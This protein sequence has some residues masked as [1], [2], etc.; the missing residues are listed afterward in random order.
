MQSWNS[1]VI[2][3]AHKA[4]G[5]PVE[6]ANPAFCKMTVYTINELRG[7]S[8]KMLQGPDTDPEVINRSRE[9]PE[10]SVSK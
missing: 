3:S 5:Y 6:I 9:C 7:H 2:T 10:E 8:L 1:V 4:V